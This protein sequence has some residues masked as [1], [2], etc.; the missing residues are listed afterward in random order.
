MAGRPVEA[1]EGFSVFGRGVAAIGAARQRARDLTGACFL[2][3][4]TSRMANKD[5]L[6]RWRVGGHLAV[7]GT[8]DTNAADVR[9]EREARETARL[10]R[11]AIECVV[12]VQAGGVVGGEERHADMMQT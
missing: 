5:P 8:V 12:H 10:D 4:V 6:A 11:G 3:S 9:V 1:H 7:G 2:V